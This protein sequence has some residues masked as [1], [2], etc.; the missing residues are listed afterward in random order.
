MKFEVGDKVR[1]IIKK[2]GD[3]G[4]KVGDVGTVTRVRSHLNIVIDNLN[5][6]AFDPEFFE[7]VQGSEKVEINN[8]INFLP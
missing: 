7:K 1:R 5:Q 6:F 8:S 3:S 4:V 2:H